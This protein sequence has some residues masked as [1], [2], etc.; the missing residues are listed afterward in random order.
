MTIKITKEHRIG[1]LYGGLSG[2]REVSLRTGEAVA[3]AL[4]R[5][6]YNVVRIDV[7]RGVAEKLQAEKIAVAWLALHGRYGE[8]GCIQGLLEVMGIPYTGSGVT[9]SA[10]AMDKLITKRIGMTLDIPTPK[11]V[12]TTAGRVATM[13]LADLGM[14]SAV[15]KPP[16]D[17]SS[18]GITIC[19]DDATL[20]NAAKAFSPQTTLLVEQFVKGKELTVGVMCGEMMPSIQIQPAE[21]FYD[22]KAKYQSK[23][24]QYLCP[25][26]IGHALQE[27]VQTLALTVHRALGCR[28]VTRSDFLLDDRDQLWFLE[29]NTLPGMTATSLVPKMA[30]QMGLSF[31]ALCERILLDASL[32]R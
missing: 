15:I 14:P 3:S 11:F 9:A 28:G 20:Q 16:R 7:D 2:E 21:G 1:V 12:E 5:S 23:T 17:G 22:Y 26:P 24:T 29:I 13:T 19:H 25:A 30:A 27:K 10:M 18:L 6:G 8:D 31:E 32:D 4:E